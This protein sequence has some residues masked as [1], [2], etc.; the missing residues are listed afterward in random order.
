MDKGFFRDIE[1]Y[2]IWAGE[3]SLLTC[4]YWG[5][6]YTKTLW[7]GSRLTFSDKIVFKIHGTNN[8]CFMPT[9][10]RDRFGSYLADQIEADERFAKPWAEILHIHVD[11]IRGFIAQHRGKTISYDIYQKFWDLHFDYYVPHI[12]NKYAVDY[13]KPALLAKLL[14]VFE[15]ARVYAEPV[16]NETEEFMQEFA[17]MIGKKIGYESTLVLHMLRVE[18]DGYFKDGSLPP[19]KILEERAQ[20]SVLLFDHSGFQL[21]TG[22]EAKEAEGHLTNSDQGKVI[23]GMCAY[24]GNVEGLVRIITNPHNA[25][26]EVGEILVTGMTRPDY[27]PLMKKAAAF[28]TDSGGVLSHAAIVAREMRKPCVIGTQ[29]ATKRLKDGD[30]VVIN[31]TKGIVEKV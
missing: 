4:S 22:E 11:R 28:I 20:A 5:D 24:P 3:W 12:F 27:L 7:V 1:W 17:K 13:M 9:A 15:Q 30:R 14:P 18:L 19:K 8:F 16:F 10:S 26:I 25:H 21:L 23:K 2:K 31:A 6:Q 29:V